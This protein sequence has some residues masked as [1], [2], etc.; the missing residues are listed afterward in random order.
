MS[1]ILQIYIYIYIYIKHYNIIHTSYRQHT[2][3]SY[4]RV[5]GFATEILTCFFVTD[6]PIIR[7]NS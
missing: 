1:N 2:S 4:K 7:L 6:L 5:A 3:Y